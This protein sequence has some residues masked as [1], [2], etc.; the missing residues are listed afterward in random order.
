MTKLEIDFPADLA[1][2]LKKG[3]FQLVVINNDAEI[4]A[5]IATKSL[6]G[7]I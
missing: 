5:T 6:A 2:A 3:D 7:S 4:V 1:D